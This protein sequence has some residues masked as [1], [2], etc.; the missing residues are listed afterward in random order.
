MIEMVDFT[1]VPPNAVTARILIALVVA[2]AFIFLCAYIIGRERKERW[3]KR[4]TNY[5]LFNRRGLLGE[6]INF[7]YPRTWQGLLAALAIYGI[8]FAGGFWFILV[9]PY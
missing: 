9:H 6:Y 4:R 8:I 2:M 7:G 1:K 3:F 5:T